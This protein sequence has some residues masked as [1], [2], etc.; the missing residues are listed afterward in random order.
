MNGKKLPTVNIS[1][2]K[3]WDLIESH[4]NVNILSCKW[5]FKI[6]QKSD[7]STDHFKAHPVAQEFSQ[8]E[9]IDFEK[10]FSP[11]MK[12]NT[13]WVLL[14]LEAVLHLKLHQIDVTAALLN[15]DLNKGIYI[16]QPEGYIHCHHSNFVYRLHKSIYAL[17]QATHLW[18]IASDSFLKQDLSRYMLILVSV[19]TWIILMD[20]LL[21]CLMWM[22]CFSF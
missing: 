12:Y 22:R 3:T 6:K 9:G 21:L 18:N 10:V 7:N 5:D 2:W 4:K 17:K 19:F 1:H 13:I 14:S 11:F 8:E 20:L 16:R 15:G